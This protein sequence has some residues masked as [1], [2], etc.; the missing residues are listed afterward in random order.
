[1]AQSDIT[2]DIASMDLEGSAEAEVAAGMLQGGGLFDA[3]EITG[4]GEDAGLGKLLGHSKGGNKKL[5]KPRKEEGCE[6]SDPTNGS[7]NLEPLDRARELLVSINKDRSEA[8]SF[9]LELAPYELS[10]EIVEQ[11]NSHAAWLTQTY[12]VVAKLVAQGKNT[13]EDY[14]AIRHQ[15]VKSAWYALRAGVAKGILAAIKKAQKSKDSTPSVSSAGK[16]PRKG[17]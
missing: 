8:S 10:S 9:A 17:A 14:A 7:G 5:K 6:E 12:E 13:A 1:M 4:L 15:E 3:P 16:K 2:R 11:M